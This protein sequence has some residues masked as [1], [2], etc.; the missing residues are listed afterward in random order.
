MGAPSGGSGVWQLP[1]LGTTG[2][3]PIQNTQLF[4]PVNCE[5]LLCASPL[6]LTTTGLCYLIAN[7]FFSLCPT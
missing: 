2:S 7:S 4:H 5:E 3:P 6:C 1:Q